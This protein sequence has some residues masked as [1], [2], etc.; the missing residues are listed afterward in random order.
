MVRVRPAAQSPRGEPCNFPQGTRKEKRLGFPTRQLMT[1]RREPS[2]LLGCRPRRTAE[3]LLLGVRAQ[4]VSGREPQVEP[5][6]PKT[7]FPTASEHVLGS[8]G[9]WWPGA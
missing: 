4:F 7:S 8:H 2:H 1:P 3:G 5:A 9:G 6:I